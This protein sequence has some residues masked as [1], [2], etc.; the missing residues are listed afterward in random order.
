MAAVS[1]FVQAFSSASPDGFIVNVV[2]SAL[3]GVF[4]GVTIAVVRAWPRKPGD[5]EKSFISA[6]FSKS[7]AA[8]QLDGIF[9]GRVLI[10]GTIG[11][12]V[13]A[14]LGAS[15]TISFPQL[16]SDST[17]TIF[18]NTAYPIMAFAGGGFGGPGGDGFLSVIFLILV[19]VVLAIC[20]G[21]II[22]LLLQLAMAVFFGGIKGAT[23]SAVT[24][25][26]EE[27]DAKE[28]TAQSH[29]IRAGAIK[30]ALTG[31]LA[32]IVQAAFTAW[33]LIHFAHQ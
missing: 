33:G 6:L 11:C 28:P 2:L 21:C 31:L 9:F 32:G 19:I 17:A 24:A 20:A 23:K 27:K 14:I 25:I 26:L 3:A 1:L 15:G 16:F 18:Q 13:G 10:S 22:G 4:A 7:L 8:P 29:P 5:I 12:L 30:G